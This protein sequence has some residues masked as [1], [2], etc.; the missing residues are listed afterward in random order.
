MQ[1]NQN[2]SIYQR[3]EIIKEREEVN[4]IFGIDTFQ[5]I[6]Q[7]NMN[8]VKQ[9]L[10]RENNGPFANIYFSEVKETKSP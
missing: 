9:T 2:F 6:T 10:G 7:I 1:S 8:E 4:G 3:K 5:R